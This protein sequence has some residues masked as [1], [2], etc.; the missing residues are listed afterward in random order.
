MDIIN[1]SQSSP[2][3]T[4]V[5]PATYTPLP[6]TVA[7]GIRLAHMMGYHI[8]VQPLIT[9]QGSRAWA[10]NI[11]F[12]TAQEAQVWFDSYWQTLEPYIAAIG[13]TGAEELALGTEYEL[14]EREWTPQW[15][16]LIARVHAV[17]SGE[18]A[19]DM[20]W[21]S[22]KYAIPS[23][24]H[25]PLLA[26]IG[27]SEYIPLIN[28]P[29]RV[30][31]EAIP[32]LWREKVGKV[33]DAFSTKLN[34]PILLS[35]IGYRDSPDALYNP[36][37]NQTISGTDPEEQAAAYDAA[38]QYAISDPHIVGTFF[39]AWSFPPYAPNG[40]LA[41]KVLYHWYTSPLT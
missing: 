8:F 15:N 32:A 14:L 2:F 21:S 24:M 19:Y 40:K 33:L 3:A 10:G 35:E 23:W 31:P 25:N 27:I 34:K 18:L 12:T 39:W 20:N 9:V 6:E 30:Q 4:H 13:R 22:L 7:A 29:Q 1:L 16:Q 38:L 36:W 5:S 26:S 28:N 11:Q 37:Q 17:F 41:S